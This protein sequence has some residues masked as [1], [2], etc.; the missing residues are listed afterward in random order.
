MSNIVFYPAND[1]AFI[2]TLKTVDQDPNSATFGRV[3]DLTSGTVTAFLS[4]S[5]APNA[6][7][8]DA[9]LTITGQH[10]KKGKW[11]LFWDGAVLTTTTL[12]TLTNGG[13]IIVV[14]PNGVRVYAPFTYSASRPATIQ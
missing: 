4:I 5:N 1:R 9:L 2:V 13:Y 11:L 14:K 10:L 7:T 12:A 8:A 3:I 6:T